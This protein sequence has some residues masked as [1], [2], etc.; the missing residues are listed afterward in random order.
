MHVR[1]HA[2]P[3]VPQPCIFVV[4]SVLDVTQRVQP[5]LYQTDR[6][7]VQDQHDRH[8]QRGRRQQFGQ[9]D[10]NNVRKEPHQGF[11][12]GTHRGSGGVGRHHGTGQG[13][14]GKQ[15]MRDQ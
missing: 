6:F 8:R 1:I 4:W 10:K 7:H 11:G 2:P 13:T 3:K 15:G 14:P 9:A 12:R 5:T